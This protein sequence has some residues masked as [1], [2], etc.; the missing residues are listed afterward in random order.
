[1]ALVSQSIKN[2][3][4]GISQ[5]PD[6]LRFPEQ[7]AQQVNGW[8]SETEGLQKRPPIVYTKSLG[9]ADVP[10]TAPYIHLI[11]RDERER[12]YAIFTGQDVKIFDMNGTEYQ[13]RGDKSYIQVPNPR[14][15][16]RMVTVADYT[17]I[18]NRNKVVEV[19]PSLTNGGTF[20]DKADALINVRG[21]QYG[22][23]L[24]VALNGI[25]VEH[26]L[27]P[28]DNAKDDPPKVDA[29]AIAEAL[30][31][32]LR[33]AH[34]GW[35]FNVGTGFIH[36]VAPGGS[37][38]DSLQTKDGY[39]DQL[40]N[41]VTHYAQ[42]FARLPI[43]APDGYMVKIVGD[44]S[45]S[46]D[47]YYV[48]YDITQKVWKETVGWNVT[49][50]LHY[51]TMPWTLIRAADGQFDL[52]YHEWTN[53]KAG[54][55]DTNPHPSLVDQ[56]INDVFFYRNRLGFLCGE[57][58]V[59][60]RTSKYFDLYPPSVAATTDDDPIDVAVSHNRISTLKY[61]VPFS[62]ELLLWSD[63]AQ[64][65]LS[66][67]GVLSSKSVELNLTTQFDVQD[68]A[69]PFGIG[70]NVYYVS[71]R[72]NY[73]SMM[74]YYAVQDVSSVKNAEDMTAHVPQLIPNGVFSIT[75]SATE[76]FAALLTTGS[77]NRVYI[78]KYLY[79]DE[80]IR[81]QAWGIWETE[82]D[83]EILAASC[84][85]ST[86]YLIMRNA[87]YTWLGSVS[88][89][90]NTTDYPDEPYRL[91]LDNKRVYTVPAGK[92]NP[93]TGYTSINLWEVYGAGMNKGRV[94]I[95]ERDGKVSE[96]EPDPNWSINA[97]VEVY[98]DITQQRVFIGF[99]YRF[100]YEFSKFLIKQKADDGSI[101]TEDSGRL[102]L[103][104]AWVNYQQSGAFTVSVANLS[105]TFTYTMAG[106]RVGSDTL[107]ATR[108]NVGTGQYR[109]P[110][111]G[112][113]LHNT[114][115][116]TSYSVTPLSIIGCGWEANYM[117]RAS[118]I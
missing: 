68:K 103:R 91:H 80:E 110:V 11:N 7:G 36:V 88:F 113:A 105:R 53:R 84:I 78:Y 17:F 92:Y 83:I 99:N 41:P 107:R 9:G 39:A 34:T 46:A 31:E 45:K 67:S 71:Q 114:V 33:A 40:I 49:F 4:G 64:F 65:V 109:F 70:R 1:M 50:S 15:D 90:A 23:K 118:G 72:A 98:G 37:Q 85:G 77:K 115:T 28:G 95:V 58:I 111:T 93:D 87:T 57:N 2:L 44:T 26:Q 94:S 12:Y 106:N 6:I 55:D 43:N 10:G 38:I 79:L 22:R 116:I 29:Q 48:K 117:R 59:L 30:A 112:N 51:H 16:L 102:Q 42:S 62:E 76:N 13:V 52:K 69:R 32:L 104:R 20:N 75:G 54:D 74:R 5:Q 100:L 27:P 86:M 108:K 25:S 63:E 60:S 35:T 3:K 61:A 73:T 66:A 56:R 21:G 101:S 24:V 18:V 82:P 19:N 89:K 14:S 97:T 81:Q 47:Q 8:S 96:F